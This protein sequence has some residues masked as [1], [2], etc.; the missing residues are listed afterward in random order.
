MYLVIPTVAVLKA[1]DHVPV[2]GVVLFEL[3]GKAD[4][5]VAPLQSG[6]TCVNVGVTW[7]TIST[8]IVAEPA[9]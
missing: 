7:S 6:P 5:V 1:G 2:I 4:G 3:V 9:H 8:S